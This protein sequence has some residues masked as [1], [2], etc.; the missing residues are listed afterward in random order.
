MGIILKQISGKFDSEIRKYVSKDETL[1]TI[2]K[3]CDFIEQKFISKGSYLK[4]FAELQ[5]MKK[6]KGENFSEFGK[7]I[8]KMKETIDKQYLFR[9]RNNDEVRQTQDIEIIALNQFLKYVRTC[10]ALLIALGD[11]RNIQEAVDTME[12]KEPEIDIAET[13]EEN[14]KPTTAQT[15][16]IKR[17]M[18]LC[19]TCA[20]DG[21]EAFFCPVNPCIYCKSSMHKS[22]ECNEVS[23][24][25]KINVVCKECKIPGHTIDP[26]PQR[27]DNENYCQYCQAAN[28]HSANTCEIAKNLTKMKE[29]NDRMNN[30]SLDRTDDSMTNARWLS[31]KTIP[32][33]RQPQ[34]CWICGDERH[35]ARNCWQNQN[36]R[37][38]ARKRGY[39]RGNY[40]QNQSYGQ[41][42]NYGQQGQSNMPWRGHQRGRGQFDNGGHGYYKKQYQEQQNPQNIPQNNYPM[43][44]NFFYPFLPGQQGQNFQWPFGP[45]QTQN[46][47]PMNNNNN[48]KQIQNN[49]VVEEPEN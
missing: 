10:P 16:N 4:N 12:R 39:Y 15:N 45:Q 31:R 47:L 36:R 8:L 49:V 18:I 32:N 34:P 28:V 24:N 25:T 44:P 7:R 17:K 2:D 14:V 21:H 42:R 40:Q 20:K 1:T 33:M 3:L 46:W 38:G 43:M 26:C 27:K 13:E 41:D 9:N 22:A 30:L 5:S 23:R 37:G 48:R 19:Q 6:R 11:P 35:F 29:I